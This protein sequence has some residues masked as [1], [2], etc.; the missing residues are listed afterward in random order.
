MM[1]NLAE[2]LRRRPAPGAPRGRGPNRRPGPRRD[3]NGDRNGDPHSDRNGD[4]N[5]NR[6]G[7]RRRDRHRAVRL[8]AAWTGGTL[9][10][11]ILAVSGYGWSV[12]DAVDAATVRADVFGGL[13]DRP[14]DSPATDILIVGSDTRLGLSSD[15]QDAFHVGSQAS[16]DGQRSDTMILAQLAA[17]KKSLTL[18]SIPRDSYVTIPATATRPEHKAKI[19]SA[20]DLGG[21]ALTVETVERNTGIRVDHYV[22]V[23][24]SA[25]SAIVDAVGGV[26]VCLPKAAHD[27]LSGLDLPAGVSHVGG[28]QALSYVRA[29]YTLTGGSDLGRIHRQQQFLGSLAD[30][31]ASSDVLADPARFSG[32][33]RAAAASVR[34]DSALS[35]EDMLKLALAVKNLPRERIRFV[36]MPL[37]DVNYQAPGIGSTVLWD[38]TVAQRLFDALRKDEPVETV[39]ASAVGSAPSAAQAPAPSASASS[40]GSTGDTQD[41]TT[42]AEA[43]AAA[44]KHAKKVHVAEA[45][46]L[47]VRAASSD[48]C[49]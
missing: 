23:D 33:V 10:A 32:L 20:L 15:A 40:A 13:A 21:P 2:L 28:V 29:R 36:S 25:F 6:Q 22:Q 12:T 19:N 16:A 34:T 3:R 11:A 42:T 38:G 17:D 37:A 24:F 44:K 31:V 27:P 48:I 30:R 49:H 1:D 9:S 4:R 8:A 45:T 46:P 41:A 5:G 18:L 35:T 26:D 47:A 14:A 39:A 43:A 7:D